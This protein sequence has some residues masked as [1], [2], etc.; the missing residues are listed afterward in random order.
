MI[1]LSLP[2]LSGNF[3]KNYASNIGSRYDY[4]EYRL[5]MNKDPL[6][7]PDDLLNDR[8]ILTYRG[9]PVPRIAL[10]IR[11]QI[12]QYKCLTD[13]DI[14]AYEEMVTPIP[15]QNL[16]LSHHDNRPDWK[17]EEIRTIVK[18]S[19]AMKSR[20][21]KLALRIERYE[22][23][24]AIPELIKLSKKPVLFVGLGPL[25][26]VTRILYFALDSIGTYVGLDGY[27][28][29]EGQLSHTQAELYRIRNHRCVPGG[30]VGG[31]QVLQSRGIPFYNEYFQKNDIDAVYIPFPAGELQDF[32]SWI[33]QS[34]LKFYGFS[35]TM[36]FKEHF[37]PGNLPA[38]NTVS[39]GRKGKETFCT[40]LDAFERSIEAL[41]IEPD[42]TIVIY[43][44][45][46]T[47]ELALHAL[48]DYPSVTICGR[49]LQKT[50]ALA[51]KYGRKSSDTI[52]GA[53]V[54]INCTPAGAGMNPLPEF[55]DTVRK[56][57]DL[58]YSSQATRLMRFAQ[59]RK[60]PYIDGVQFW[61][62]QAKRQLDIFLASMEE[63]R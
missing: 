2:F 34:G 59:E 24:L 29:A 41:E 50:Q 10:W 20:I 39:F 7:V 12:L 43:G 48:K 56:I 21:L 38:G 5:D 44:S 22:Q 52:P 11:K 62:W 36:P 18:R 17:I 54:L 27:L 60:L 40:D 53:D 46:A 49:N 31:K 1:I 28:T 35:V 58:P 45:G 32:L 9:T 6:S 15:P 37:A 3:L 13:M 14:E 19:N 47:A 57:I 42:E 8:C 30:I 23:L 4:I 61:K 16:I 51:S 55:P 33:D 63:N 25:G 26:H